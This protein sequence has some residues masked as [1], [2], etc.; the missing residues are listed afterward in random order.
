MSQQSLQ[1]KKSAP[2]LATAVDRA[3]YAVLWALRVAMVVA[4]IW[5][6]AWGDRENVGIS[7]VALLST[8]A[9]ALF[10]RR[11]KL[12]L[13]IEF[14]VVIV[15][16]LFSTLILGEVGNAY[17]KFW[18]W[19]MVLHASSGVV[20]GF[21]GFLILYVPYIGGRLKM[22]FGMI[23]FFSFCMG[24]AFGALWEM[25]E[26]GSDLLLHTHMQHGNADTMHDLVTDALG[27]LVMAIA[28]YQFLKHQRQGVLHRLLQNFVRLNPRLTR[29]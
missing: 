5:S 28:G 9:P 10:E 27:A 16:F 7:L 26:F 14:H 23:A 21:V 18:W 22:S 29:R 8:F 25:Y 15:L 17:I 12:W 20:I 6:A 4:M 2:N 13:P 1:D 24:L 19:D 3:Q 11:A